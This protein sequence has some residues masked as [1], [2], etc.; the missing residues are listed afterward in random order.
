MDGSE[1]FGI[2][3]RTA[4]AIVPVALYFL[5]LGLLNS[6]RRPQ[7]LSGRMDFALL[8]LA[9]SPLFLVPILNCVGITPIAIALSAAALA[10]AIAILAPKGA[11]WVIYNIPA[12][13]SAEIV[14]RTLRRYGIESSPCPQG[15]ALPDHQAIVYLSRFNFLRNVSVRLEGGTSEFAAQFAQALAGG[16]ARVSAQTSPMAMGLLL[17]ATGMLVAPLALVANHVPEVV[18][19]LTD[20]I[21]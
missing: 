19:V 1:H 5:V 3:I 17:V 4:G 10:A 7:V 11:T 20:L 9:L 14:A 18:R 8:V 21:K 15:L 16:M 2:A 12:Q 6:R 13:E